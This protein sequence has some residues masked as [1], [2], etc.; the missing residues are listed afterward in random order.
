MPAGVFSLMGSQLYAH[1]TASIFLIALGHVSLHRVQAE[2]ISAKLLR[3][4]FQIMRLALEESHGGIYR[5]TSKA[6][7]DRTFARA[8]RKIDHPMSALEFWRLVA[9]VVAEIKC[10]HTSIWPPEDVQTKLLT[11]IPLLPLTV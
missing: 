7:M 1:W 6:A 4:D 2:T 11:E 5:Y 8:Y 3:E 10:G 9:P